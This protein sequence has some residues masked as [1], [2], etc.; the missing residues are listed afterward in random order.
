M[1][2]THSCEPFL[3]E[4]QEDN[5]QLQQ[6]GLLIQMNKLIKNTLKSTPSFLVC[7]NF[8]CVDSYHKGQEI[9]KVNNNNHKSQ[10]PQFQRDLCSPLQCV[11][12]ELLQRENTTTLLLDV[13]QNTACQ[14]STTQ[15]ISLK[16]IIR[17]MY[18]Y[19][20]TEKTLAI[21]P[22]ARILFLMISF[23]AA[24]EPTFNGINKDSGLGH[25][26]APFYQPVPHSS[27]PTPGPLPPAHMWKTR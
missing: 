16:Q 9:P 10:K 20:R 19:L 24:A 2:L 25:S 4:P 1:G 13:K 22:I 6:K 7:F 11:N 18:H 21:L 27:E 23:R 12:A 17:K 3:N 8:Q 5:L 15:I 14:Q 26:L